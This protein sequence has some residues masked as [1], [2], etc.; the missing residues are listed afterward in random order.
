MTESHTTP[1]FLGID[2][3]GTNVKVGIVADDGT[4]IARA[5]VPTDAVKGP[6][7]G[8]RQM[9]QAS[10]QALKQASL[11][12]DQ[13]CA[14]GLATPGTMDIPAGLLLDPPNLPGWQN[15]PVRQ[16]VEEALGRPTILQNDANAAA[17]GEYW[18]GSASEADSLVFFTLGTGLGGGLIVDDTIVQGEHSHGSELGHTIIE[19]DC[20]RLC[21][22]GQYGTLEAYCSATSL[23]ERFHEAMD[24]GRQSSV[25][26]RMDDVTALSPLLM[27]EEA[28]KGDELASELILEM[29]RCLGTA[30]TSIVHVIDPTMVLLGGAMT[31]GRHE[32]RIGREFL[33]RVQEEFRRRA[34]P[35]LAEKVTIDY[36]ALGGNAGFIGAAGCARRAVLRGMI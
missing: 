27:A 11:T 13:I 26:D 17:Y 21:K 16:K 35:V 36:A 6:D 18:A 22:T 28:E 3:G 4:V 20:G 19:M 29:A 33:S 8:V 7:N 32:T 5:S 12:T 25:S 9:A 23:I 30:T 31:F 24:E 15:Y 34:F 1:F 14:V 2:V 10:Q